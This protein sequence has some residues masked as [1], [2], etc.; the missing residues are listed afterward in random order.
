MLKIEEINLID[1]KFTLG[2]AVCVCVGV[3]VRVQEK[4]RSLYKLTIDVMETR[5]HITS[6]KPWKQCEVRSIGDV[7]VRLHLQGPVLDFPHKLVDN[8]QKTT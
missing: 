8:V 1:R 6:R 2:C 7:P 3:C 5:C 4:G